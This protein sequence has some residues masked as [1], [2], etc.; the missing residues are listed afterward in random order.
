[1]L[2]FIRSPDLSNLP[3]LAQVFR[4]ATLAA[5]DPEGAPT[6]E[7][8]ASLAEVPSTVLPLFLRVRAKGW[9]VV[10][11]IS[12]RWWRNRSRVCSVGQERWRYQSLCSFLLS[13]IPTMQTLNL[14]V[15]PSID[16]RANPLT[17]GDPL[18]E[19]QVPL[20]RHQRRPALRLP[21]KELR[22]VSQSRALRLRS[23]GRDYPRMLLR[24]VLLRSR[25]YRQQRR[26][27]RKSTV[28]PACSSSHGR[29]ALEPPCAR[30]IR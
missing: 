25:S 26:S 8:N 12:G 27:Y 17:G 20:R 5:E 28:L 23:P 22:H 11:F 4:A 15:P 7:F 21:R 6:A 9:D 29:R 16:S 2:S 3:C 19:P 13:F 10:G 14:Q 1:M 30:M 24:F 18:G